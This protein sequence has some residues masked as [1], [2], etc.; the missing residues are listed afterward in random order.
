MNSNIILDIKM[1]F[2]LFNKKEVV[3]YQIEDLNSNC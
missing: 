1:H 2:I 3:F